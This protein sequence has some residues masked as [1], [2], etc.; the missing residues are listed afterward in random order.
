M[1]GEDAKKFQKGISGDYKRG[2]QREVFVLAA[3]TI[4][5]QI[6]EVQFRQTFFSIKGGNDLREAQGGYLVVLEEPKFPRAA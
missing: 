6:N 2:N 4:S 1:V 5:V 3:A